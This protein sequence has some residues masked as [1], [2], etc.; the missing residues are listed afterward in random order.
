MEGDRQLRTGLFVSRNASILL[1]LTLGLVF[2]SDA[3][4]AETSFWTPKGPVAAEQ[5]AHFI[6]ITLLTMVAVLPVL[7]LVPFMLWRYRYK[8]SNAKFTPDW[9]YSGPLDLLMWGVPLIIVTL[10]SVQLWQS[11]KRLDPYRPADA[12]DATLHVQVVGLDWKWL[13]IYPD[14]GIA[15][16]GELAFPADRQVGLTLTSDTVMQSFVVSALAGQI[17]V[18]PGMETALYLE[19]D[20][21]GTFQGENMQFNGDGFTEQ[22]F[23]AVGMPEQDFDQWVASVRAAGIPLDLRAYE[24]VTARS[25]QAETRTLLGTEEMPANALYFSTVPENFFASIVARY[26][27]GDAITAENQPGAPAAAKAESQ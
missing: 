9:G 13:F 1:L 21:P 8:N 10:L 14:L 16:M 23:D 6:R 19:A 2:W 17:Y 5:K 11:V 25:T 12:S 24:V 27:S 18:M 3:V 20:A 22:K 26:R 4:F 15:T 7:V